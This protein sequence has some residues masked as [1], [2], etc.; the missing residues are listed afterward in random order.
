MHVCHESERP[1]WVWNMVRPTLALSS[2]ADSH[3]A[4]IRSASPLHQDKSHRIIVVAVG[5]AIMRLRRLH[6]DD[7]RYEQPCITASERLQQLSRQSHNLL[8][9]AGSSEVSCNWH[10]VRTTIK[11]APVLSSFDL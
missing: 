1:F 11:L 4:E 5:M 2:E 6:K 3:C 8:P 10:T 7:G 9:Y